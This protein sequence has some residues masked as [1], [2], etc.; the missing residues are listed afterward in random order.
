MFGADHAGFM[1]CIRV[2]IDLKTAV[3][4]AFPIYYVLFV[5]FDEVGISERKAWVP[6]KALVSLSMSD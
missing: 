4:N 5:N 1:V 2:Y 6:Q 3:S